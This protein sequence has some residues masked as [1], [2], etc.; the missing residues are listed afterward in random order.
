MLTTKQ[1]A[2][3]VHVCTGT[4]RNYIRNGVGS[5]PEKLK[6]IWVMVGRRREYRIK[7]DDLEYFRKKYLTNENIERCT[8]F[9]CKICGESFKEYDELYQHYDENHNR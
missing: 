6:A 9:D 8:K 2:S 1:A 7:N 5:P 3:Q 4:V